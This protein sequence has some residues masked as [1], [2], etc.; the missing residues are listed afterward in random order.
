MLETNP[1]LERNV[2]IHWDIEMKFFPYHNY[3]KRIQALF[4]PL[5]INFDKEA[6]HITFKT[7]F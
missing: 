7:I 3:T 5:V 1:N 4:K 2:T 6:H